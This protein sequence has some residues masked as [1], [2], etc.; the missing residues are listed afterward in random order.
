LK[1]DIISDRLR[2]SIVYNGLRCCG[3]LPRILRCAQFRQSGPGMLKLER[4]FVSDLNWL[5]RQYL[6]RVL[7]RLVEPAHE[8]ERWLLR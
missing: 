5:M 2:R 3:W 1:I 8:G 4:A 7:R 6:P